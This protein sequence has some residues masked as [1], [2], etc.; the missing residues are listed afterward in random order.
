MKF[1]YYQI[2][3]KING[4]K[5]I[6]ITDR[7]PLTRFAEHKR[8]LR[9]HKHVNYKL[10][11]DWIDYGEENFDFELIESLE[12]ENIEIGYNHEAELI[13]SSENILYNLAPGG[14]INPMYSEEVKEKMVKTKQDAVPNIYQLEE[15]EENVFKVIAT[16]NSQKEVQRLLGYNQ[17]NLGRAIKAHSKSKGYYWITSEQL[18]DFENNW[19]PARTKFSPTAQLNERG[20]IVKV[21]HNASCFEKEYNLKAG[22]ISQSIHQNQKSF[23]ITYKYIDEETYYQMKPIQLVFSL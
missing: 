22:N 12:C 9:N 16:F 8:A 4:K 17:G 11:K 18:K 3:N 6:G 1:N 7:E 15:I 14:Q 23:G 5:Y 20:E 10:Q 2:V 21:H 13:S 19:R